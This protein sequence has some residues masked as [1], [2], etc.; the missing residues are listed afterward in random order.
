M[1]GGGGGVGPAPSN[2]RVRELERESASEQRQ[3]EY[4]ATLNDFLATVLGEAN[5]RDT[6]AINRH[7]ETVRQALE[8]LLEES[9]DLR[10]GGSVRKHTYVDGI[11]DVDLLVVLS[12]DTAIGSS[13]KQLLVEFADAV[14]GRLP[15]AD[16]EVGSMSVKVRFADGTELQLLP[17]FKVGD[18]YRIPRAQGETWSDVIRPN[19]FAERLTEVNQANS[20]KV[21]PVIKLFK[22]AQERL[23]ENS[24]LSGYHVE[25]I[26]T[27]AFQGY[28]GPMDQS[29]MFLHLL[30]V[31][32]QATTTPIEEIT[33][34]SAYVDSYL[35]P[36]GSPE[37]IRAS[38][39]IKR[40]ATRLENASDRSQLDD[41][42][43]AFAE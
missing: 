43:E 17:A 2:E 36:A 35:G 21:V 3:A 28:N 15:T 41:W 31:A 5:V 1:C 33:G 24:R 8:G 13:P 12:R 16:V 22:I 19:A 10:F 40:L 6:D 34:Q 14:R 32:A 4:K 26:A 37:R 42:Y 25:A 9:V 20:E 11:S 29:E 38:S 18:G 30:K 23:P 39:A 27:E 7:M